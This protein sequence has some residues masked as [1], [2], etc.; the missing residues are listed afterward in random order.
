MARGPQWAENRGEATGHDALAPGVQR[1]VGGLDLDPG[2][3][4]ASPI[5]QWRAMAAS[6]RCGGG[7]DTVHSEF[8]TDVA[9][10]DL[11][12]DELENDGLESSIRAQIASFEFL[13]TPQILC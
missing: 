5:L 9:H 2:P 13:S 11:V 10:R 8:S 4:G 3:Q 7:S 12:H 6:P 1:A